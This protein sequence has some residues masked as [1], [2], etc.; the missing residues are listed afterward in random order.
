[1]KNW[2]ARPLMR[3]GKFHEFLED[4]WEISDLH[5]FYRVMAAA[6][7]C[8]KTKSTARPF[9]SEVLINLPLLL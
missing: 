4:E 1:M 7:R 6:T 9:M 5:G 3:E 8:T 2:Q